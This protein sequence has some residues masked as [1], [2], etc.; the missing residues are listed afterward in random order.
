MEINITEAKYIYFIGIGGIG[1]SA[2]ARVLNFQG[3]KV[4]GSD[5]TSS[6]ITEQLIREGINIVIGH[7]S[8]N[9]TDDMDLVVYSVA[10]P[11]DNCERLEAE[12]LKI[13]QVTYP[14]LLGS[15]MQN[16]YAIGVSGT[17]GKTT[18][19]A[20]LGKI[21]VDAGIDP[22]IILGSKADY[23]SGNS[24]SG[25][26]NYFIF[27]SDEYRRA[28]D[29]YNPKMAI[30][31][32]IGEDHLDYYKTPQEIK[33][34]FRTYFERIPRDGILII[35]NDDSNSLQACSRC[36]AR[37][38]TYGLENQSD[39]MAK[40]IH[41]SSG[42]QYFDVFERGEFK[43]NFFINLPGRFNVYDALSAIAGARQFNIKWGIIRESLAGFNGAWR[44]FEKLGSLGESLVITDY[45]HTP[46]AVSKT[47]EATKE[48]FPSQKVLAVFQPHQFA[49]T[50]NL[51]N[52][53]IQSFSLADEAIIS[54][55]YYVEGRENPEDFDV[56]S[57]KLAE[58]ASSIGANTIWGGDLG[59]TEKLIRKKAEKFDIILVMGAGNIY[60]VA[61]NLAKK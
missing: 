45:A 60:D 21:F 31:T 3:K 20:M 1:V 25:Q 37:I 50:K 43:D 18:T 23:L 11:E 16:K 32:Y 49:R 52:E 30:N 39:F 61:K 36:Q 47:I 35:N 5:A 44:R 6:E 2:L 55:I 48:F 40:C 41:I 9:I 58:E 51:F 13:K 38:I 19:T 57:Q 17:N 22:T 4:C 12:K 8:E 54:D 15:I 33:K 26:S 24:R 42:R 53:F 46:D 27:E 29:N 56:S 34:A 28:F 59:Q 14:E 10:V 7:K